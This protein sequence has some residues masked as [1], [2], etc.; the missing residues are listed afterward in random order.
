MRVQ[1]WKENIAFKIKDIQIENQLRD[2]NYI[3]AA[4]LARKW[5][6]RNTISENGI[7][8][9][10]KQRKIYQ[11]VTGYYIPTLLQWGMREKAINYAKYLCK[12][13][14]KSGAWLNGMETAES[15]FNTGQVLRG[16]IAVYDI[17][18]ESREQL[19]RGCDWLVSNINN[20]GR[21]VS[22]DGTVW[23]EGRINSELIHLYC[24]PP[25]KIAG[26]L[27]NHRVYVDAADK[28]LTYYKK[29][30]KKDI[31]NFNYLSH[32]YAYVLEALLDLGEQNIVMDAMKKIEKV[33]KLD[34]S[35]PAYKD[36]KW[37]CSTG[38]FQLAV[39][40]FKLG[41]WERGNKAFDYAVSLQN[42]SGG[43]YGGYKTKMQNLS[44]KMS[45]NLLKENVT[46]F[47]DE[48]ISWAVKYFFDA[49][50]Y[51][52]KL[53]FEQKAKTFLSRIERYDGKFRVIYEEIEKCEKE[54]GRVLKILDIGC[55]KGR[56]LNK[57]V[58]LKG[59]NQ[60]YGMDISKKVLAFIKNKHITKNLGSILN[61]NYAD[62]AFD[63]VFAT[64]SLE[65]AIFIDSA[66]EEMVRV[67]KPNG[68][69]IIIDKDSNSFDDVK[70]ASWIDPKEL[71]TKQW[72]DTDKMLILL[73][74]LG[75]KEINTFFIPSA[76][77]NMY[78]AFIG[79]RRENA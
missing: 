66:V 10:S 27:F 67:L 12:I 63:V 38:L 72:I 52:Q 17:F 36:S 32:F 51:R 44:E 15:V 65:H 22:T 54:A 20:E 68:K 50:Y 11:E 49:L 5:I 78:R 14:E 37:V 77:G 64:E 70:Y 31:E 60:Y 6:E 59:Q 9:T 69:I 8:I 2:H 25:L 1:I 40:W 4:K 73:N 79:R 21:L 29:Q 33:Q 58:L 13:Q 61:I 76:E 75:I 42:P 43:W 18:P 35:V 57:L 71:S 62:A 74:R 47:P 28:V 46:Y 16:L 53:E 55:G 30:Y 19:K 3:I 7:V 56:Y 45:L 24:L 23:P 48:E 34:G 39:I 26:E 41:N